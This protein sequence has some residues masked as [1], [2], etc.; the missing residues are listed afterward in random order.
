MDLGDHGEHLE[1]EAGR[2]GDVFEQTANV[3][4]LVHGGSGGEVVLEGKIENLRT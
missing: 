2:R 1:Q 4:N 3:H